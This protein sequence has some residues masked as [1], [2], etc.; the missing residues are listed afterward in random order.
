MTGAVAS[1]R[2]TTEAILSQVIQIVRVLGDSGR[3][4]GAQAEG[5]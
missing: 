2:N 4:S 5:L 1:S 3:G